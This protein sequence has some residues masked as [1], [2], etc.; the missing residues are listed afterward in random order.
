[1]DETLCSD[2]GAVCFHSKSRR[3]RHVER[4]KA[5]VASA[6]RSGGLGGVILT[7]RRRGGCA[8]IDFHG[9]GGQVSRIRPAVGRTTV[10]RELAS[11]CP[12]ATANLGSAAGQS[13]LVNAHRDNDDDK[14]NCQLCNLFGTRT[15]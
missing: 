5:T 3:R 12:P 10:A 2:N 7:A 6:P 8:R 1:M 15:L 4:K 11:R 13:V 14:R 9:G